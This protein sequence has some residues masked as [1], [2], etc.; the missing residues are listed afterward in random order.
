MVQ[1]TRRRTDLA[2]ANIVVENAHLLTLVTQAKGQLATL[3][4][5]LDQIETEARSLQVT[6]TPAEEQA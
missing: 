5:T 3:N 1:R 6:V 2:E 4:N